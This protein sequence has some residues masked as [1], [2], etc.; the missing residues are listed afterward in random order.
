MK[1]IFKNKII[2]VTGGTGSIGSVVVNELLKKNCKTIRVLS[3]DENGL[4][5]SSLNLSNSNKINFF[6]AMKNNKI[7]F[8]YGD[9]TDYNRMLTATEHID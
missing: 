6:Q 4:Y 9:I 8:I 2:L 5:N 7:R 3:N 1:N